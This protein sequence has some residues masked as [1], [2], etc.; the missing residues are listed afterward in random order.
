MISMTMR[1]TS[2]A[3]AVAAFLVPLVGLA[4]GRGQVGPGAPGTQTERRLVAQFDKDGNQ[5]LN[6]EER[7]AARVWLA[8]QPAQGRG[9]GRQGRGGGGGRG[10]MVAGT[11]G[12]KISPSAVKTYGAEP[13]Y[14]PSV[15][16]TLF[17]TFENDEW[18]QELM[19]F[20]D[21]DVEVPATLTVD[22][23]ALPDV[24]V[25]FRGASSFF[26][27]PE[28]LKHS[29]NIS[30]D[31]VDEDQSFQ[32][33]TTLNLL[34]ANGDASLLKSVLYLQAAR[35]YGPAPK[36]N[37]VR[38]VLNG[39]SWGIFTSAQQFN[40]QLIKESF[41]TTDGARWKVPGSPINPRGVGRS[42]T[43]GRPCEA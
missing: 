1:M 43:I 5:R 32:D 20:N 28:G 33:Y 12:A 27:V 13:F 35:E 18:E 2:V 31:F 3:V 15:L 14:D 9:G 21:S 41:S 16:R 34:N 29:M 26:S 23:K 30:I 37:F 25:H 42:G 22:G 7:R 36:A 17:F 38:V 10:G 6:A 40:K 39:E 8:E 24:G 4:Q 11:P 19:A